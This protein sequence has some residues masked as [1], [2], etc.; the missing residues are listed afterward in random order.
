MPETEDRVFGVEAV[1]SG[2]VDGVDVGVGG[3]GFIGVVDARGAV[4]FCE[5]L[6][7]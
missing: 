7:F 5:G 6:G 3:E 2:D 4:G 1:W